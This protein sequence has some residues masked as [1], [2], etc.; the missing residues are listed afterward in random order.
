MK[1]IVLV[2]VMMLFSTQVFAMASRSYLELARCRRTATAQC[3][4]V[5]NDNTAYAQCL[6]SSNVVKLCDCK[7]PKESGVPATAC[8]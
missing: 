7:Y 4:A 5:L 8:N 2:I 3:D 1:K 6:A